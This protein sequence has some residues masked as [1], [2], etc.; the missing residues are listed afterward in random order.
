MTADGVRLVT[1]PVS[2]LAGGTIDTL[3]VPGTVMLTMSFATA[4]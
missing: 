1:E 2:V 3:I 4:N